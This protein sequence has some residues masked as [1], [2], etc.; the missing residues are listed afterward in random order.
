MA[1]LMYSDEMTISVWNHM[2]IYM[3]THKFVNIQFRNFTFIIDFKIFYSIYKLST[4]KMNFKYNKKM[5]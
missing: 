4:H 3:F 1:G 2:L 5:L